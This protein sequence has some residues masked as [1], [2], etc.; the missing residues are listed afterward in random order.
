M[1]PDE[2]YAKP[3]VPF[4]DVTEIMFQIQESTDPAARKRANYQRIL[5]RSGTLLPELERLEISLEALRQQGATIGEIPPAP[6][7][8]RARLGALLVLAVRRSLFWLVPQLQQHS[9]LL[10]SAMEEELAAIRTIEEDVRQVHTRLAELQ[11]TVETHI[12]HCVHSVDN[13]V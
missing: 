6:A 12:R 1:Y 2:L 4:W 9:A 13:G 8:F 11:K 7:T 5:T 10:S 3:T